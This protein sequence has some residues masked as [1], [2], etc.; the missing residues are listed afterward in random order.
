[1]S[2]DI[3]NKRA[4][5]EVALSVVDIGIELSKSEESLFY[6]LQMIYYIETS[7]SFVV[8]SGRKDQISSSTVSKQG[9]K[10]NSCRGAAV[11]VQLYSGRVSHAAGGRG[12]SACRPHTTFQLLTQY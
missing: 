4:L 8:C 3:L 6:V 2:V 10:P 11:T 1:M 9:K 7:E 5:S 12:A